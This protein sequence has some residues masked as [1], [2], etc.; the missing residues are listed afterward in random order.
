V[1]LVVLNSNVALKSYRH[2]LCGGGSSG[3]NKTTEKVCKSGNSM[4]KGP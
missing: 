3:K 4:E 1:I 2:L